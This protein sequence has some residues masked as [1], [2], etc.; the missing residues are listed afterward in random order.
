[1]STEFKHELMDEVRSAKT[2][3][4]ELQE[5]QAEI[6]KALSVIRQAPQNKENDVTQIDLN[7]LKKELSTELK[8][9]LVNEI[10]TIDEEIAKICITPVNIAQELHR[11][12][13]SLK[14]EIAEQLK[15][16]RNR[17]L[18]TRTKGYKN[19]KNRLLYKLR[20]TQPL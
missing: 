9:A 13:I 19:F 1:L 14:K 6:M 16:S 2:T 8:N 3:Q 20:R 11:F 10:R 4:T 12:S 5:A 18:K 7:N 17:L 15:S